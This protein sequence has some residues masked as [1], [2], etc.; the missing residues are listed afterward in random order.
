M[1]KGANEIRLALWAKAAIAQ[2]QDAQVTIGGITV[3]LDMF[4][5]SPCNATPEE[6]VRPFRFAVNTSAENPYRGRG[7]LYS[8]STIDE[9][10]EQILIDYRWT[11]LEENSEPVQQ[12]S[13]FEL[14]G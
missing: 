10:I 11:V 2:A 14:V 7:A 13:L 4:G 8:F 5:C 9:A 1:L 3:R 6:R 12:D